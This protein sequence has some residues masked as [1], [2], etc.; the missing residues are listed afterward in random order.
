ML[1]IF[2]VWIQFG[3]SLPL[4]WS[5]PPF[6]SQV[7]LL[8]FLSTPV[9]K[10]FY[11]HSLKPHG[12]QVSLSW[13]RSMFLFK[14]C[15]IL[16]NY[17]LFSENVILN[18]I[19]ISCGPVNSFRIW[20]KKGCRYVMEK[21]TLNHQFLKGKRSTWNT[22]WQTAPFHTLEWPALIFI[23][24]SFMSKNRSDLVCLGGSKQFF[25]LDG[26]GMETINPGVF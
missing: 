23:P 14:S 21:T 5:V 15:V 4:C 1:G 26:T 2:W 11:P 6:Y 13:Y 25:D 18:L 7:L 22:P 17:A 10:P 19:S 16:L 12:T 3:F 20:P 9:N 24:S 8:R